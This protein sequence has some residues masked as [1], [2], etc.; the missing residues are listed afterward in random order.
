MFA[1]LLQLTGQSWEDYLRNS[2]FKGTE[3]EWK[4]RILLSEEKG[5][6][7]LWDEG[8]G[9]CTSWCIYICH[10]AFE[11]NTAATNF[12]DQ[13]HHRAAYGNDGIVIDSPARKALLC[14][15]GETES[16]K[17]DLVDAEN[18]PGKCKAISGREF[19]FQIGCPSDLWHLNCKLRNQLIWG[20]PN[21][22]HGLAPKKE[23]KQE[24]PPDADL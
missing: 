10:K 8:Y 4:Q 23:R 15:P 13:G 16:R 22:I 18:W 11:L 3:E 7:H 19:D 24:K 1:F 5:L 9:L 2:T 20:M 17:C 14:R 6:Q 21:S 12:G